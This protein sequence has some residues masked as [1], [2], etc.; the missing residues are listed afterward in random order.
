[1]DNEPKMFQ[2]FA[3]IFGLTLLYCSGFAVAVTA[4]ETANARAD[5]IAFFE[6]KIRPVLVE[7]CYSCHSSGADELQ[8]GLHLDSRAGVLKGGDSGPVILPG[9]PSDSLLIQAIRYEGYEMPPDGKLPPAVIADFER[10][11]KLGAPDPRDG[12]A[13]PERSTIDLE[14]GRQFWSFQTIKQYEPPEVKDASWPLAASDRFLLAKLEKKDLAPAADA[15]REKWLRRLTFDLIGLPP[16]PEEI[17]AF[18]A[19]QSEDAYARVVDRLLASPH[20]GERWGRHWLDVARFAESS[21]G[22]R[23]LMFPD[24]WRYRD[25]VINSINSDKPLNEFIT[26]Q[27]AGD[28]LPYKSEAEEVEHI[29]ATAYLELGPHN[30]EEQDK[31]V[32][33]MDVADEQIDTIG[34]GLLGMT[35]AC[36]RCHDHKFDPIP[37]QDYYALAGI[38]RS[39]NMLVHAN[40]SEWTTRTLPMPAEQAAV[41]NEH[42]SKVEKLKKQ[43]AATKEVQQKSN[44]ADDAA[45]KA[46]AKKIASLEKKLAQLKKKAPPR[47]TA[48][49][50][51]EAEKIED[52]KI[53]IRGSVRRRGPAVPRG[54]LQ[55]ATIGDPPE[56]IKTESGR[57]ELAAW[58][59]SPRNPLTARV[60]VNRVWNY[61]FGTGLVRTP[62]N[63]GSTGEAPS[64]PEL[65]DFLATQFV[66]NGWSTKR[67]VRELTLSH[68]YRMRTENDT[69]A[70]KL[71][72]ENRLFWRM[73]RTR[74]DAES[75]RDAMLMAS[76]KL[77][78][79][80]G[81]PNIVDPKLN[82]QGE[83]D[84]YNEYE[85][86]FTDARRSVYTPAFRNR[87]HELFEVFDF[88]D[89]NSSVA[90]RN[91]TTV[92]PQALLMLNSE[93]VM[94]QARA[95]AERVLARPDTTDDERIGMAFRETLGRKPSGE[96]LAIARAAVAA[97]A[98]NQDVGNS[99]D[100]RLGQ[101]QELYQGL[102]GCIDFRYLD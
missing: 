2:C 74:L 68:A 9:N 69:R 84:Q 36:A 29:I 27:I 60:Y 3:T 39:T 91:V 76:G 31:R 18:A 102:F 97:S 96:E 42:D 35:I 89:Q 55:V 26:E 20:F 30:Y 21:G 45:K 58:I 87:M 98:G 38:F 64:H 1:M 41:V 46:A 75:L 8:A 78:L 10:W 63:F 73:N 59:V 16:T 33:E 17:D 37:T 54:V 94:E 32:L 61:L 14:Q 43:L 70:A 23:S 100:M 47:P 99:A 79:R 13:A 101:W 12:S 67:L 52:C 77:D 66:E 93:F 48:M 88:A 56:F 86:V 53:C 85:Y 40:V 92:A 72:P 83:I 57:R 7:K 34:R 15:D 82:A 62:D 5:D 90:R 28:L 11:V 44:D 95:A 50:V 19:D 24:A 4:G 65:L 49:A 71:D 25:Y 80:M 51:H 81:G 22:G 6:A